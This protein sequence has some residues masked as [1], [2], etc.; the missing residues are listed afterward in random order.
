V[1]V[2]SNKNG[3]VIGINNMPVVNAGDALLHIGLE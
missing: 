3:Y 2:K 1:A